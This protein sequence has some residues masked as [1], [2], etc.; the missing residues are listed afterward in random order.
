M[1]I[2]FTG[3]GTGGHIF[4]I[5]AIARE[6]REIRPDLQLY[7]VGPKDESGV[8]SLSRE[9]IKVKT[10]LAGKI[11]RY[12]GLK[13]FLQNLIDI[14]LKV[15]IGFLQSFFY[16]F[17]LFPDLIFSKG[18]YGALSTCFWGWIFRTP[19]ILHESDITPGL[20]NKLIG[21]ISIEIFV[22][23]S[24]KETKDFPLKKMI[25]VGNP[26]RKEILEG[27][28]KE[29]RKLFKLD[30]EKPIILILGGS[31]GA[32]RINNIVLDI[33][34]NLLKNFQII[35]QVGPKNLEQVES[36][37]KV[38]IQQPIEKYY[39][40]FRFLNETELKHA[41]KVSGLV[42]SRAGSGSIFE[43]AA[44]GKPSILI[45]LPEAAQGHQ[46]KNAYA[47]QNSKAC[48]VIEEKNLTPNFFLERLKYLFSKPDQLKEM[49]EKAKAFSQPRAAEVIAKYIVEYLIY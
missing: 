41:L 23:F 39:H 48:V 25:S 8:F 1:R 14:F 2:I 7:Y 13:P 17:F 10:I 36:E 32:Q 18:G 30:E 6:L 42:V 19:I 11:R 40:L 22:S 31:Q 4:P 33:L 28:V 20:T 46:I 24:V 15:P 29:A 5:I 35:H 16:I 38:M 45:P 3:G 49:G 47:Y 27:K 21:K 43:I 37:A 34:P 44:C 9:G 12:G 26:V